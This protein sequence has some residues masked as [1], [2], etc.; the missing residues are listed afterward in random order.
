MA[1]R[2]QM[3]LSIKPEVKE[4]LYKTAAELNMMPSRLVEVVFE[5]ILSEQGRKV[6]KILDE[7]FAYLL[8]K[9]RQKDLAP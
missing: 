9:A 7:I 5:V 8:K 2:V 4:A 3:N 6:E 1:Q